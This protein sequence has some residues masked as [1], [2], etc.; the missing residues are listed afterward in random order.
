[1]IVV[2]IPR[3]VRI[4]GGTEEERKLLHRSLGEHFEAVVVW[5]ERD[6]DYA[7]D[8]AVNAMAAVHARVAESAYRNADSLWDLGPISAS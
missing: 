2:S 5:V 7:F 6:G 8:K 1:M 3:Y 4:H